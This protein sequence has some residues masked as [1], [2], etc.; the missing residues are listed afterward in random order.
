MANLSNEQIKK[1]H[2]SFVQLAV[3]FRQVCEEENIWYSLAC[4]TL[5]G[6]LR[7]KKLLTAILMLTCLL[8]T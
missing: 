4:G 1:L 2:N 3:I 6:A 5:L 7:E 8:N